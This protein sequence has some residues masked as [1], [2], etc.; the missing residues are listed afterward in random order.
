MKTAI[1]VLVVEDEQNLREVLRS[2]LAAD[3]F[4]AA[5]APSG[6]DALRYLEEQEADVVLLDLNM[7]AMNGIEVLKR[8]GA[9]DLPPEVIVLTA[10]ADVS[11]AVTAMKLGAYDYLVKPADLD[12]LTILIE[13]AFEKKRLRSENLSLRSQL[14]REAES[15]QIIARDPVMRECLERARKAASSDFSV[16][17]SGESGAGKELIAR[18]I[19]QESPRAERPFVAINCGA[20]P[21]TMIES[22]LF[23][24]EK[25]A[26]TGACA[27]KEGL[28]ELANE[29]TLFLDE[30]G[31]MPL[32]LQV[33]L[34]RVLETGRFFRLGGTR[35]HRVDIRVLAATNKDLADAIQRNAFRSDLYYRINGLTVDVP[36]LRARKQDIPLFIDRILRETLPHGGKRFAPE[37]I[38]A[39]SN[40]PWPGNVRELQNVVQRMLV[41]SREDVVAE[42]DLPGDLAGARSARGGRLEDIEREHILRVLSEAGGHRERAA[43]ALGIHPRT[44]R[45][46]LRSYGVRE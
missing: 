22:E 4:E 12:D 11:T 1:R 28:L 36:P 43:G 14:R 25:G 30:I 18:F 13:K 42:A 34:L 23:G 10:N 20:I 44:L 8:I 26:F 15:R 40:Y 37:V 45:R 35:E 31:D 7:P 29:G 2:E 9:F 27:R 32:A 21:E 16:L 19:H 17:I 33:K 39:L 24:H 46:K 6:V 5:A 41:L 3:G 38:R